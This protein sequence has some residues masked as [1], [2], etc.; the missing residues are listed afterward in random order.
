MKEKDLKRL[1]RRELVEI[2]YAMK[3]KEIQQQALLDEIQKQLTEKTIRLDGAGSIAEAALSVSGVFEAAQ[4]AADSYL[5][6]LQ[7]AN[8][9]AQEV[10]VQARQ[11]A[12]EIL[13][14]ARQEADAL[15]QSAQTDSAAILAD[16]DRQVEEKWAVFRKNVDDY[17]QLNQELNSKLR[18]N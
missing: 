5:Q 2:I 6:S 3:Q 13:V 14:A 15:R 9:D 17:L 16:A 18:G 12:D 7:A 10:V 1:S 8:Q 4:E 11:Q